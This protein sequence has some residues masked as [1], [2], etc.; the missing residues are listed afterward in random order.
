MLKPKHY[1]WIKNQ[2]IL[3]L[4]VFAAVLIILAK[5]NELCTKEQRNMHTP[6]NRITNKEK[7]FI[8]DQSKLQLCF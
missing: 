6:I 5:W 3:N 7:N 8:V 4:Y 2:Q 1:F